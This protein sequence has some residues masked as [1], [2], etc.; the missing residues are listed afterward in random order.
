MFARNCNLTIEYEKVTVPLEAFQAALTSFFADEAA[1]GCNIT[2]PF[3]EQAFALVSRN[4]NTEATIAE[5]V[6]TIKRNSKGQLE[7][8]N[9]DGRGLVA[10]LL[11]HGAVLE[12]KNVLLLGAGGA[13]KGVIGPLL[14]AGVANLAITNRTVRK[15]RAL[16]ERL[17]DRHCVALDA[18]MLGEFNADIVINSTSA[19]LTGTLPA[20]EQI[21]FNRVQL[22]YDMVYSAQPTPF[23]MYAKHH[24]ARNSLDGL[25]MLVE[26]AAA[27]FTIWTGCQPAT[28]DVISA[29]RRRYLGAS[30]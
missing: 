14:E 7:G 4:C 17:E 3:K 26:Q 8:Y 19:S 22:A 30:R 10:D 27:A 11:S 24:G 9:T 2:V 25:G 16:V 5:A 20:V 28:K 21:D 23:M 13:A 6:N 18:N 12:G 29:L 1:I 15:A